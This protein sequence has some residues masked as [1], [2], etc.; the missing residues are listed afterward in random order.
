[1]DPAAYV[2]C[3][4]AVGSVDTT[5]RLGRI[6]APTLVIAGELDQGTPLSM[7]QT[8]ADGI[9]GA[10]LAIIAGASHLSV[11][12]QPEAFAELVTTFIRAL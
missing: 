12:E 9:P 11:I 3:C 10:T 2:G 5:A 4:N 6:D 7:A 8:L 1:T